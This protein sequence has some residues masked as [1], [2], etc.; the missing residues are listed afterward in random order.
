MKRRNGDKWKKSECVSKPQVLA[1]SQGPSLTSS[2]FVVVISHRVVLRCVSGLG[3]MGASHAGGW[4][5]LPRGRA[6]DPDGAHF[7]GH[8]E[9]GLRGRALIP[10]GVHS[11]GG[12]AAAARPSSSRHGGND[13]QFPP[14]PCLKKLAETTQVATKQF[15]SPVVPSPTL[16]HRW[17]PHWLRDLPSQIQRPQL[18]VWPRVRVLAHQPY[19]KHRLLRH[20]PDQLRPRFRI[21]TALLPITS[22]TLPSPTSWFIKPGK[23]APQRAAPKTPAGHLPRRVAVRDC[24]LARHQD[25]AHLTKSQISH[26]VEPR[27]AWYPRWRSCPS[28]LLLVPPGGSQVEPLT[29]SRHRARRA[30]SAVPSHRPSSAPQTPGSQDVTSVLPTAVHSHV[31][32]Q[33]H[34]FAPVPTSTPKS[35]DNFGDKLNWTDGCAG[36]AMW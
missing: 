8:D 11:R 23:G 1:G 35:S 25:P 18:R 13:I 30:P 21:A 2:S 17:E 10:G 3:D 12:Q 28:I 19:P 24:F 7:R 9:V 20:P 33:S 31:R 26:D 27:S 34:M 32:S 15:P 16:S 22:T 36:Y 5:P 6:L 4:R 29:F 14:L